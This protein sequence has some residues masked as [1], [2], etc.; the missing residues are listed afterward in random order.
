M[1]TVV[2]LAAPC[3]QITFAHDGSSVM[4]CDRYRVNIQC[5][6]LH[7]VEPWRWLCFGQKQRRKSRCLLRVH[8]HFRNHRPARVGARSDHSGT[9]ARCAATTHRGSRRGK[10]QHRLAAGD[11][12]DDE[13]DS[14][15]MSARGVTFGQRAFPLIEMLRAAQKKVP[16]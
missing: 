8:A 6:F 16:M 5:P 2:N 4:G 9:S 10:E 11:S 13:S 14:K 1:T 15:G 12:A 3:A 7:E